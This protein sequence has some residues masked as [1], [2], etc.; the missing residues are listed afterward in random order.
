MNRWSPTS[1]GN[2]FDLIYRYPTYYA[3]SY[4][5]QGVPEIRGE[6]LSKQPEDLL[7]LPIYRRCCGSTLSQGPTTDR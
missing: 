4:T 3:I 2:L 6:L 7:G 1:F 5:E